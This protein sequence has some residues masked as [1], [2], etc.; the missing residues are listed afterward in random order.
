MPQLAYVY[1]PSVEA[2]HINKVFTVLAQYGFRPARIGKTDPP[3]KR[4]ES[5]DTAVA[6]ILTN[7]TQALTNWTF[8]A[9]PASHIDLSFELRSDPRWFFSG[10]PDTSVGRVRV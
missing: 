6:L 2:L 7:R 8:L 1:V 3:R 9:D 10:S 5:V 4:V